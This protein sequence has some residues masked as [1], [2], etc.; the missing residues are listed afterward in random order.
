MNRRQDTG[1]LNW[2]L[3]QLPTKDKQPGSVRIL[4]GWVNQA[5]SK[6]VP[7]GTGGR[8]R[9]LVASTVAVFE[10]RAADARS[11]GYLERT[12]PPTMVAHPHWANDYIAAALP[13]GIDRELIDAVQQVNSWIE[14]IDRSS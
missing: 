12:W 14:Q 11:L 13:A 7:G 9:W 2:K 1:D 6:L 3:S 4:D 10:A 5:D 8:L